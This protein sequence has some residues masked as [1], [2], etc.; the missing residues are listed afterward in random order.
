MNDLV[1]VIGATI[2]NSCGHLNRQFFDLKEFTALPFERIICDDGTIDEDQK[3][4][5][6]DVCH[7]HFARWVEVPH[8]PYGISYAFNTAMEQVRTPWAFCV[9]DGL[10]PG[11][12][13][14]ETAV[15]AIEKIGMRKWC[16]HEVGMMGCASFEDWHL[17]L[18]GILPTK[19]HFL[20]FYKRADAETYSAFWGG[21]DWPNWNDGL[22]CWK[23]LFPL[24][25]AVCSR[26]EAKTWPEPVGYFKHVVD[27]G[28]SPS[29][30]KD[31]GRCPARSWPTRRTGGCAWFPGAFMLVNVDAWRKV[32]RFRDGCTFFE[33]HLGIRMAQH[34][35][36]SL[37]L[38][39]PPWLHY[40]GMGFVCSAKGEG[41]TPR[42]HE[43]CEGPN[44]LLLR[45]FGCDGPGHE[46]LYKL[47]DRHFPQELQTA[48]N[49]DLAQVELYADPHWEDWK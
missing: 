24:F 19:R 46:D 2:G 44:G 16:G 18:A 6:F 17:A 15:D 30:Y 13:W 48:I 4:R 10:R 29:G 31:I 49:E 7:A 45:D 47:V 32:G 23:R 26:P 22:W 41:K 25:Q 21:A 1:T 11:W 36:V 14:L 12:G 9:E 40:A 5:Q 37:A 3:R 34:G 33:G 20:D 28:F 27:H 38:E 43:P 8:P 39:F 35:Y 42:H